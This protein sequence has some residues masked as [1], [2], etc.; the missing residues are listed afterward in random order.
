MVLLA[1][2]PGPGTFLSLP[3][4]LA[5]GLFASVV[6]FVAFIGSLITLFSFFG[7][8]GS[9]LGSFNGVASSNSKTM[10]KGGKS[11]EASLI[12]NFNSIFFSSSSSVKNILPPSIV[13]CN[14]TNASFNVFVVLNALHTCFI[15]D[16]DTKPEYL[17]PLLFSMTK[18]ILLFFIVIFKLCS[19]F[20]I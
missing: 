17:S 8:R 20:F 11:P 1:V 16:N 10:E 7:G 6:F 15:W 12:A 18:Y 5:V 19:V 9:C 14:I 4:D 3:L 2:I 13:L